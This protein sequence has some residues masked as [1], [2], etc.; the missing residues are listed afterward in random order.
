[1]PILTLTCQEAAML[2]L[3]LN[4]SSRGHVYKSIGDALYKI[5]IGPEPEGEIE[6]TDIQH[7]FLKRLEGVTLTGAYEI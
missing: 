1:M 2:E 6:V 5:S 4:V 3:K 7:D